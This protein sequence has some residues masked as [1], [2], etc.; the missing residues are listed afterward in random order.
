MQ[1]LVSLQVVTHAVNTDTSDIQTA[2]CNATAALGDS[3]V[4]GEKSAFQPHM[5]FPSETTS[6][7]YFCDY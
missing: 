6:V 7:P 5:Q 1:L 4:V 3:D 2:T